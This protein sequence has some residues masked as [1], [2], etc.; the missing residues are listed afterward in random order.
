MIGIYKNRSV[1]SVLAIAL[2]LVSYIGVSAQS[3]FPAKASFNQDK[4]NGCLPL[5]VNFT[6][7]STGNVAA[8]YWDFGNGNTSTLKNPG[9]IYT[10]AGS[11]NILLVVTDV[12]GTKDSL[13]KPFA[14]EAYNTPQ[15]GFNVSEKGGCAG[16]IFNFTDTSK[17]A[18]GNIVKWQ[19][20]YGDGAADT[21]QNPKHS[22]ATAGVFGVSLIV[23]DVNGCKSFANHQQLI[24]TT[25]PAQVLFDADTKGGC[26]VPLQVKFSN[27]TKTISGHTYT[28]Q[29]NF[30]NGITATQENPAHTYT[31]MGQYN[32]QLTVT[33]DNQCSQTLIKN[34]FIKIGKTKADFSLKQNKGCLP[35]TP[36]FEDKSMGV[37]SNAT[38]VWYFGNGDS[39]IGQQP[40]YTYTNAGTY[41]VTLAITS[42]TGCSDVVVKQNAVIVLAAPLATFA[43]NNTVSCTVPHTINFSTVNPQTTQWLWSFGDGETST[44]KNPKKVYDSAGVF[45]VSLTITDVNG[46]TN[47]YTKNKLVKVNTQKAE[48]KPSVNYGCVPLQVGFTNT[49]TSYFGINSYAW[50]FGDGNTAALPTAQATYNTAGTYY[51]RLI[52]KDNIGCTDTMVYDSIMVGI[53][54]NPDFYTDKRKGCKRDMRFV[55]FHN[56]TDTISQRVD[57]FFW[58]FG[59]ITSTESNPIIDYRQYPSTYTVKL[60]AVSNG[61]A[62]TMVKKDY[63]T[64]LMPHAN[65]SIIEDPCKLDTVTFKNK[66]VGANKFSW[67][68][69]GAPISWKEEVKTFLPPGSYALD[70]WVSDTTTG[71]WDTKS[72]VLDIH[73]PLLPGF[74][75]SADSVC[76]N[77]PFLVKDTSINAVKTTFYFGNTT[78]VETKIATPVI[79]QPS[80]ITIK[81]VV[82]DKYGCKETLSKTNVI[83]ILGPEFTPSIT[84]NQ[85]CFPLDAKLVKQG[86]SAHGVKDAY[87][88][89]GVNKYYTSADSFPYLFNTPTATMH[90]KGIE[91]GLTVEDNLGCKVTR[92]AKVKL[93]KPVADVQ[94]SAQLLCQAT[95]IRFA[96]QPAKS[97]HIGALNYQWLLNNTHSFNKEN[98]TFSFSQEGTQ[99]LKLVVSEGTSGCADSAEVQ[100]PVTLKKLK[101]AFT[102]DN[103][104]ATCPP[105]VSKFADASTAINTNIVAVEWSFGDGAASKLPQP[106]KSYFLPGKY[107]IS[108]KVIDADGCADSV[109]L[110]NSIKIGGPIGQYAKDTDKGC[111]PFEV[112]FTSV[113]QN[114]KTIS[115]DF[116]NGTIANTANAKGLYTNAGTYA[117]TLLLEDSMGCKVAYPIEPIKGFASPQPAFT[118][119]G[120]CLYDEFTFTNQTDTT[121][122]P[123]TF[124][125]QLGKNN[126]S[127]NYHSA[128]K[129]SQAGKYTVSLK[130]TA[131]NGC[132]AVATRTIDIKPLKADFVANEIAICRDTYVQLTDKSVAHAGIA[133]Y[134]WS[135]GDGRV[136]TTPQPRFLYNTPGEFAISLIIKDRNG[137]FDTLTNGQ[138][139][140]VFDTLTPPT[141]LAHRVTV[142]ENNT[143]RLE[144]SPFLS[145]EFS[146]YVIYRSTQGNSFELY[147]TINKQ[148]DTVFID[149]NVN[150]HQQTYTYKVYSQTKC[151]KLSVDG[152]SSQHTSVL[153]KAEGDTNKVKVYWT[154]Y[155]GWDNIG[156]YTIHRLDPDSKS[157]VQIATVSAADTVYIDNDVM[158]GYTYQYFVQA[159]QNTIAPLCSRSN[160]TVAAPIHKPTVEAGQIVRA[161]VEDDNHVLVEFT[162][163]AMQKAPIDFY[164]I[165]KSTDGVNYNSVFTTKQ[166]CQPFHDFET[167]VHNQSYYYRIRTTDVCG[168]VSVAGNVGKTIL[169]K[170][171][172]DDQENVNAV[173]SQYQKWDDGIAAYQIELKGAN[174]LYNWAGENNFTDTTFTDESNA[175]NQLPKVCYR[176]KAI[177]NNGTISYSNTDCD[178]GRSSLFVPNAFTPN[179][180]E[181][182]NKFVIIGNFIK[183]F[184]I[185]VYNRYGEKLFTS[186]SLAES[187]DGTYKGET[188][189]EGA[190]LYVINAQGMDNKYHNYSGTITLLR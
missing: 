53:K 187:W 160:N 184:E 55:D 97:Q 147:K 40:K 152:E 165:E 138:T 84:P 174:G 30:G 4:A 57:G 41:T 173:W 9:A 177:S 170:V 113:S 39:A 114:A 122:L 42:P 109:T 139:I 176:V 7:T 20:N 159:H 51:P 69:D 59:V 126:T 185:N 58:D 92:V 61:C 140:T 178:K 27:A 89:D 16:Q 13:L 60:I 44:L 164:T 14:V 150:T 24:T 66:S 117:P 78:P 125:W 56:T 90:S 127:A 123:L 151:N 121:V 100:I 34:N 87:W 106:V 91:V 107:H 136:E 171:E 77:V 64:I 124:E 23:T 21:V 120:K 19:W 102:I 45:S 161:T 22:F 130:A 88:S 49:S 75:V 65:A 25:Q 54:T 18:A 115:W 167:N 133:S 149:N 82:E 153:V 73:E 12:N 76:A 104:A 141:P 26:T 157:F 33:D 79:S 156:S 63:I 186:T 105:L 175:Y 129:Y 96:H 148:T 99:S 112:N 62:D 103:A 37:P 8:Y 48:F 155:Y 36:V 166:C 1:V 158:C 67:S 94:H 81:M 83:K 190:Y 10:Q 137:C 142:Q 29:W 86:Y 134:K 43:H 111:V 70:L 47:T 131:P 95:Q 50:D 162:S 72:Y 169:L 179:Q 172:A 143:I 132:Q 181:H 189:Q 180:D 68:I 128:Q 119:S 108:Y 101:A 17:K 146:G 80:T 2:L 35:F 85:G 6:N 93:S 15:A 163:P 71:C 135:F 116:G 110:K 144:F 98:N 38:W 32:V 183:K 28:Y 3:Q 154:R 118:Q 182:N 74:T 145:R 31:A 46:C 5:V 168:D 188:A 52:I 11:Y